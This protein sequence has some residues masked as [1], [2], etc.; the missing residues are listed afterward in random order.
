ME[1]SNPN[2]L[3]LLKWSLAHTDG[4]APTDVKAMSEEDKSF[5]ERVMKEGIKDE[6]ARMREIMQTIMTMLDQ[7]SCA[8]QEENIEE[9]L[10]E[11]RDMT[12]Q[13]DMAALF[14]KFGGVQCLMGLI[15]SSEPL[16]VGVRSLAAGAIG[17]LSQNNLEVQDVI[18][19]QGAVD[20]LSLLCL[21]VDSVQLAAKLLFAISCIV[22][23]HAAAEA[24]F[25]LA[26]SAR[27]FARALSPVSSTGEAPTAHP[28][29]ARRA[30][31]LA[32]ALLTS[33]NS[34]DTPLREQL[35]EALVP[36][37]LPFLQCADVDLR[38]G[39]LRL[40]ISLAG[41]RPGKGRLQVPA[42]SESL[43]E[44]LQLR[45][46]SE[47]GEDSSCEQDDHEKE[48]VEELRAALVGPVTIS[49]NYLSSSSGSGSGSGGGSGSATSSNSSSN[50]NAV[51]NGSESGGNSSRSGNT[52]VE[53]VALPLPPPPPSD[54][55]PTPVLLL[56]PPVLTAASAAP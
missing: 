18:Y 6:P 21:S 3:G 46:S 8:S 28:V 41:T 31:F 13:I 23:N 7:R 2:W 50:S 29:L 32:N 30:V 26:Y 55:S 16:G 39:T 11:L 47:I 17:T 27:V 36:A 12:E 56:Q 25:V 54:E 4:T 53:S 48:L 9:M 15:E 43:Q 49:S 44:G 52:D 35:V 22:R 40:L 34:N 45:H 42:H 24:H 51:S 19:H 1:A 14:V 10:E 33:D 38:E 37:V 5:L 20:K